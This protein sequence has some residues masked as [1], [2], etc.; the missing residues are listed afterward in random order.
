M[1]LFFE[2]FN[3]CLI[4]LIMKDFQIADL[5]IDIGFIFQKLENQYTGCNNNCVQIT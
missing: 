3:L 4:E 1:N 2:D 5:Y